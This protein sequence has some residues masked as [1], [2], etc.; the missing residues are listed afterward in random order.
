MAGTATPIYP[1]TVSNYV[2]QILPATASNKVALVTG[3]ANGTKLESISVT[4]TDT[5]ARDLQFILTKGGVDYIL[6][7]IPIPINSG[8]TNALFAIDALRHT[9]WPALAYDS[10]GNRIFYVANGSVL[11]VKSTTTVTAAKEIDIVAQGGDF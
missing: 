7:T 9:N 4:S 10:N 2:A 6:C 5:T 1:Q 11:N 8:N 3:A